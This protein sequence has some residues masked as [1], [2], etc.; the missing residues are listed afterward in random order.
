LIAR[1][2]RSGWR[3]I[4]PTRAARN[5]LAAVRLTN[6]GDAGLPPGIL[7]IYE[8]RQCGQN[9]A[10]AYG[11]RS[12]G[13]R[14]SRFGETRLLAYALDE[15]ITI[16]RDPAQ[17]DRIASGS[18]VDGALALRPAGAPDHDLSLCVVPAKEARQADQSLQPRLS[19]WTLVKPEGEGASR[20]SEG[21]YRIPFQLPGVRADADLRGGAGADPAAGIAG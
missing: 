5:P 9:A 15:K 2:R 4:R 16:E 8:P 13:C 12:P 3:S 20:I 19:G 1:C 21:N 14:A 10:A 17:T 7:T 11:R 18:I 6:D